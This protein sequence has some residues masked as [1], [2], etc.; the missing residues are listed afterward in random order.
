MWRDDPE[1]LIAYA[2]DDVWETERLARHLSGSTFY[3]TQM[4][5][6]SYGQVARTGPAAKIEALFVREYLRH[7]QALPRPA[8]GSQMAG[9][10]RM[11]SSRAWWGP[12]SIPMLRA[13]TPRSC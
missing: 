13:C 9:G 10:I 2:R 3:L 6:M 11:S 1:R 5:P 12:L 4:L 8:Q 7:K